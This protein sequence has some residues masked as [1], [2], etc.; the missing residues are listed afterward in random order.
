MRSRSPSVN[1]VCDA[2]VHHF[3]I[4]GYDASSLNEIAVMVGIRKAS[5]YTH[6]K[7]KKELFLAVLEDS[8]IVESAFM[9]MAFDNSVEKKVPGLS[10]VF[11]ITD[12]YEQS[13]YLRFL[14]RTVY[15]PPKELKE[16]INSNYETFLVLLRNHFTD[17]LLAITP[18]GT[19]TDEEIAQYG[20]AYNGIVE[21]LFVELIYAGRQPMER[22]RNALWQLLTDSLALHIAED[23]TAPPL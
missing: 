10:Y 19:L 20:E 21:S 6:F 1:R 11:S 2:A 16:T 5:L 13:V 12:R 8:F 15:L 7:S 17:Q 3:S 4:H 23:N 22:R 18:K 9:K 14:L